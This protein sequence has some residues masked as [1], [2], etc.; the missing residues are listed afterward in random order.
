MCERPQKKCP[1][2]KRF[3]YFLG[4]FSV[5]ISGVESP[6]IFFMQKKKEKQK[7]KYIQIHD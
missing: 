4:Y 3:G 2:K 1:S 7:N 6:F 5:W